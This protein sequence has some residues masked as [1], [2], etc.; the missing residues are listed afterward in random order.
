MSKRE[1]IRV[2]IRLSASCK[3]GNGLSPEVVIVDLS[4][5]GC[6]IENAPTALLR[7]EQIT[8]SFEEFEFIEGRV[9]WLTKGGAAG[10]QFSTPIYRT[11][12][13]ALQRVSEMVSLSQIPRH[14]ELKMSDGSPFSSGRQDTWRHQETNT[15]QAAENSSSS[16]PLDLSLPSGIDDCTKL[17]VEDL[18]RFV[19]L[20]EAAKSCGFNALDVDLT[21]NGLSVKLTS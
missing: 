12:Y 15:A 1:R 17:P 4:E 20:V 21:N 7:G 10:I 13:H 3:F 5:T 11:D 9:R 8:L 14:K 19:M 18:T 6:R 2:P 16:A